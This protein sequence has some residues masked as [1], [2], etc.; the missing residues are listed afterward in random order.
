MADDLL[1]RARAASRP[2]EKAQTEIPV[3]AQH[4]AEPFTKPPDRVV[5]GEVMIC[6][7]CKGLPGKRSKALGYYPDPDTK[8]K[9][10]DGSPSRCIR[11]NGLG[12]LP[13]Q[14]L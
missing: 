2:Q 12:Y 5:F 11:C 3:P 4:Y 13:N 8:R 10:R 1:A 9:D 7:R 6:P 14:G